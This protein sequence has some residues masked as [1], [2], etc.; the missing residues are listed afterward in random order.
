MTLLMPMAPNTWLMGF[1][2]FALILIVPTVVCFAGHRILR[3][4]PMLFNALHW[5]FGAYMMYV[6]VAG[7]STLM[8]G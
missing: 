5:I 3:P 2:I 7:I 8:F 6:F 4:F 1:E